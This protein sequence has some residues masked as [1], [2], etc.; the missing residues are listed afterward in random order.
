MDNNQMLITI[1][2]KIVRKYLDTAERYL[3]T[4]FEMPEISFALSGRTA[5]MA[6]TGLWRLKF[7]L[8]L[9]LQDPVKAEQTIGHEVAH[10]VADRHFNMRCNHDKHWKFWMQVF[11]LPVERCHSYVV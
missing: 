1:F 8:E 6:N 2:N 7:N 10:L 5:G 4:S 3:G 9:L 11:D